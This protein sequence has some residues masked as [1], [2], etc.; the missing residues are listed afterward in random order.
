MP[1]APE[2]SSAAGHLLSKQLFQFNR[3]VQIRLLCVP[4]GDSFEHISRHLGQITALPVFSSFGMNLNQDH[5]RVI[6]GGLQERVIACTPEFF[7][8]SRSSTILAV[9]RMET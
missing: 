7:F 1:R 2:S 8:F 6:I 9:P 5:V 4:I 3:L